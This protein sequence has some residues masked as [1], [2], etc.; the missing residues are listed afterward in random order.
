MA[1]D[2]NFVQHVEC[3]ACGSSDAN[4]LYDDGH[5][6][7]FACGKTKG[8][9]TQ[10]TT[11]KAPM[12]T[13]L[14]TGEVRALPKRNLTE[15][16]CKHWR[17]TIGEANGKPVQIANYCD[18]S[19][20]PVAQKLRYPDKTF[21]FVGEPKKA[22]LYGQHLWRDGGKMLVI[23][24]GE[25]DA[26]SV[27]QLQSNKWPVVSVPHGA[28]GAAKAIAKQIEWLMKFD[29]VIF[30]FD[31]DEPGREAVQECAPLLPPGKAFVAR[32][33]G[34]KDANEALQA[35]QGAKVI[36]AIWGAK[37]YR[38]DG[39]VEIDDI[40]EEAQQPVAW[41]LAWC[42]E[43]LTKATYGRRYGELYALGAGTGIGKTD[44]FTQQIEY[45][46]NTLKVRVGVI[47][48]EQGKVET[49]RRIAGK[50]AGRRFHVPDGGWTAAEQKVALESLRGKV[51]MY[52]SFGETDWDVVKVKIRYMAVS[53][54]I[55]HI[56]LD[57]LTAMAETDNEKECI[58]QIMKEMAGLAKELGLIIHFI[59]HLS[60]P[61]GK[62][63]EEGGRVMIKHFKGSRSIG[64]WS[65]FMFGMERNQQSEDEEER[66]ITT[67]RILKD[68]YTGQSTGL[69]FGLGYDVERGRLFECALPEKDD[70]RPK[71]K[72]E[73]TGN[74]EF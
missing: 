5:T 38:P 39:L 45:D 13:D 1:D 74:G 42:F 69:V 11:R 58:E 15:E 63:H 47:Y 10:P 34:F 16:T 23:T 55:R 22:G 30:M 60:T 26:L 71:F 40:I 53:L 73:T 44:V 48:L 65:Y 59:S 72:D 17:Y 20:E 43:T 51:T 35:G 68:R 18:D 31:D 37:E 61:E 7:C 6:H 2:S 29:K 57:H 3:E 14:V 50:V 4:A 21:K 62:P 33:A 24:E 19:G 9:G 49:A 28:Q 66:R 67:F 8:G 36:E 56:F 70:D 54:G 52:D 27:S 32:I 41:G 46:V 12:S 64:F 25:I